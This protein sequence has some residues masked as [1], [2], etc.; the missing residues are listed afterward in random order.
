MALIETSA[1]FITACAN[2]TFIELGEGSFVLDAV[3]ALP[4]R[5][6]VIKGQ[7]AYVTSIEMADATADIFDVIASGTL[8]LEGVTLRTDGTGNLVDGAATSAVVFRD[9][10]ALGT[11]E[12]EGTLETDPATVDITNLVYVS[13]GAGTSSVSRLISLG[14]PAAA[15]TTAVHALIDTTAIT[16]TTTGFTNPVVPRN[17]TVTKAA[18]WDGGTVTVT[19]TDQFDR[20]VSETFPALTAGEEQGTIAFKTV[21]S[22]LHS[23]AL[24]GGNGYSIG[25]GVKLGITA[26]LADTAGLLFNDNVAEAGTFNVTY[27]TVQATNAPDASNVYKVL[28]NVLA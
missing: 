5:L 24:A 2:Q 26:K 6:R 27:N 14:V 7:G 11:V 9:V 12:I 13:S 19:G 23:V 15:N 1:D 16:A 28:V 18:S 3:I 8:V 4:A 20:V 25:T 10:R 17:L 21:V 22:S